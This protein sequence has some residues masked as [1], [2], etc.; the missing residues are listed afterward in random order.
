MKKILWFDQLLRP[1]LIKLDNEK[2]LLI[3]RDELSEQVGKRGVE[4]VFDILK[5][6]QIDNPKIETIFRMG[7][8]VAIDKGTCKSIRTKNSGF[9][10]KFESAPTLE[11]KSK[12]SV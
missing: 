5:E 7:E 3:D 6:N 12:S 9:I 4:E 11:I 10:S 8:S 2:T 1:R